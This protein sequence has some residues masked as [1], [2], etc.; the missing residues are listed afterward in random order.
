MNDGGQV[1]WID[2][3]S[4]NNTSDGFAPA[5]R[6]TIIRCL[7]YA[8]GGLG[9]NEGGV[10]NYC[11]CVAYGNT[12]DGFLI[13]TGG[14]GTIAFHENNI[15]YGNGG[16]GWNCQ[17]AS[18]MAYLLNCAGGGNTSGNY[19]NLTDTGTIVNVEGFVTLTANPF[20]NPGS[21]DFSLNSTAG[22]GAACKGAGFSL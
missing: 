6:S 22:G 3:F 14:S 21:G 13:T 9:Y 19:T 2:C 11:N 20:N 5:N 18:L 7:S 12:S 1:A 8:N 4:H 17:A 15:S 16:Y 10:N